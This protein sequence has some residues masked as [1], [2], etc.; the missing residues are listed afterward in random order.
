MTDTAEP[1]AHLD[2]T[3]PIVIRQVEQ[4]DLPKLE[5]DGAFTKF[6]KVFQRGFRE[7]QSGLRLM[8]IA[9]SNGAVAARLF[10]LLKSSDN[11]IAN[12]HTRAYLY[13]FYVVPVFRKM[14]LGTH[15]MHYAEN[16]LQQ[17][18]FQ[19]VSLAVSKENNGALRLYQRL[20]YAV[21]RDDPGQWSYTDHHGRTQ[22]V[23]EP[24]WILEKQ[25]ASFNT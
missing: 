2:I 8:L 4:N 21:V 7:Q 23:K 12:G 9:D 1:N 18:G 25:L 17:R 20:G 19:V 16:L 22:Q 11:H 14:G 6:R 15:M 10:I 3:V 13:S 5:I 24:C